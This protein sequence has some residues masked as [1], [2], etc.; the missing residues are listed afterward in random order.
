MRVG[1]IGI[2]AIGGAIARKLAAKGH[3]VRVANS[4]GVE[5]VNDFAKEIGAT[6]ADLEGAISGAEAVVLSIPFNAIKT[7]PKGLFASLPAHVPVID[8]GNY[9]PKLRD[10]NVPELDSGM[11]ESVWVAR[12]L[13][14]PVIKAFNNV[15]EY[16]LANLGNPAGSPGRLAVAVAGDDAQQK[17]VALQIVD[18]V[19][20]DAL[21]TGSLA[22]S[23]RQQPGTPAYCCDY[24]L[25]EMNRGIAEAIP[26]EGAKRRD[27]FTAEAADFFARTPTHQDIVAANRRMNAVK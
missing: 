12:Q 13:G 18:E 14:R 19:G 26:G 21:D 7:L 11:T 27:R 8:T 17:R 20:F 1:V 5:A 25:E 4:R 9:Y 24:S 22:D 23:W 3:D 10:E 15:L 2:G 16:T 6:P